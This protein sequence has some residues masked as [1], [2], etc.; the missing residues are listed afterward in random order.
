MHKNGSLPIPR[1][2]ENDKFYTLVWPDK[3]EDY[4]NDTELI[5]EESLKRIKQIKEDDNPVLICYV[6][7]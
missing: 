4:I 1:A 3:L 6:L 5:N 2:V 7:K